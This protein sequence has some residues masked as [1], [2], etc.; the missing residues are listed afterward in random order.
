MSD[1]EKENPMKSLFVLTVL[2]VLVVAVSCKKDDT[3]VSNPPQ[4][5]QV[6]IDSIK[7]SKNVIWND[8]LRARLWGKIGSST[9]YQFARYETTRDSFRATVK[10]I[11]T[12]TPASSCGAAIVELRSAIYRIYPVYPGKFTLTI[13]QPGGTTLQDTT[14]ILP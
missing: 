8:T 6:K 3:F 7:L 5:F 1:H 12:Y 13:Q 11:G 14:T 9:C 2:A 4:E 10:V